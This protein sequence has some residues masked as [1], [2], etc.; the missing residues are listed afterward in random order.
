METI[1]TVQSTYLSVDTDSEA[2]D[3]E[4]ITDD[5]VS[6]YAEK[7]FTNWSKVATALQLTEKQITQIKE[8]TDDTVLQ[9]NICVTSKNRDYS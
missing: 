8:D 5:D 7:I 1:Y 6:L 3:P 4:K 9:V 2:V